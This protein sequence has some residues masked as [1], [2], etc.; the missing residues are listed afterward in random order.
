MLFAVGP[1]LACGLWVLFLLFGV[2][3][4]GGFT[5][6]LLPFTHAHFLHNLAQG[7]GP[8]TL[9]RCGQ[10]PQKSDP[11]LH[12]RLTGNCCYEVPWHMHLELGG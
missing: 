12:L 11:G 9:A 4:D 10:Y 7:R 5:G 2:C 1:L 6:W 3:L 8:D